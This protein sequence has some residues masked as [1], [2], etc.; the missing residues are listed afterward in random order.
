MF[1]TY[2][3]RSVAFFLLLDNN[4][5]GTMRHIGIIQHTHYMASKSTMC[6]RAPHYW[7]V[8]WSYPPGPLLASQNSFY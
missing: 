4:Y 6:K 7:Y 2:D 8:S 3:Y 5:K 1:V